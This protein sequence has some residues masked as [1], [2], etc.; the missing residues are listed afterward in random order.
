MLKVSITLPPPPP[1]RNKST[2]IAKSKTSGTNYTRNT[3]HPCIHTNKNPTDVFLDVVVDD[4]RTSLFNRKQTSFTTSQ[5]P[6]TPLFL[7]L[8]ADTV[9]VV[10]LALLSS[11]ER[12]S[13]TPMVVV[14][15][16]A[17]EASAVYSLQ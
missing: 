5:T 4:G 14:P 15:D 2:R 11:V 3:K 7:L 10:L 13:H 12:L 9:L 8:H 16:V 6:P 1:P 17:A